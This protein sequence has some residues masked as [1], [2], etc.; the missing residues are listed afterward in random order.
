MRLDL[1]DR[2][3][4][5]FFQLN[6]PCGW[7]LLSALPHNCEME[8][9]VPIVFYAIPAIVTVLGLSLVSFE[10]WGFNPFYIFVLLIAGLFLSFT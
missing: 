3:A 6:K 4:G 9:T 5:V 10:E 7:V 8:Q 2:A 1:Y